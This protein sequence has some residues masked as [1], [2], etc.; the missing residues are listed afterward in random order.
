MS[1]QSD[2]I[3]QGTQLK[4]LDYKRDRITTFP[5]PVQDVFKY[6]SRGNHR[7][8]AFKSHTLVGIAG[9]EVTVEAEIFNQDGSTVVTNITHR[10]NPPKG[11]ETTM[12]GG[13]FSGAKF[14][15]LTQTWTAKQSLT[16]KVISPR[17]PA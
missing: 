4:S 11:I 9:N 12:S 8:A 15:T 17:F 16:W 14:T 2:T 1:S 5:L 13:A 10:L 3:G 6:M 7:H